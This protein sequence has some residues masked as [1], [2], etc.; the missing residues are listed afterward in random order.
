MDQLSM[1]DDSEA[2]ARSRHPTARHGTYS[3]YLSGCHCWICKKAYA[4]YKREWTQ[5][6]RDHAH[7]YA[8]YLQLQDGRCAICGTGEPG[9]TRLHGN[10]FALD[11]DH[12]TG[13]VR[14][15]LCHR[16]N[17]GLGYLNTPELLAAAAEYLRFPPLGSSMQDTA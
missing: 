11:H 5:R 1:F 8:E 12:D 16:C 10:R 17:V 13:L 7:R 14:G 9:G 15:L 3:T 2:G 4:H 6:Q